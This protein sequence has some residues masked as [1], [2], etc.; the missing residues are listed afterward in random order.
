MKNRPRPRGTRK[1]VK[2]APYATHIRI[3]ESTRLRSRAVA[4]RLEEQ[5]GSPMSNN[6]VFAK[7]LEAQL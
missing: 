5:E 2:N 1:N 7:L 4:H 6:L 3:I